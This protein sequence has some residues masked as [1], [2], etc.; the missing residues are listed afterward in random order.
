M[1]WRLGGV[2]GALVPPVQAA[3]PAGTITADMAVDAPKYEENLVAPT[4]PKYQPLLI[5]EANVLE[6]EARLRARTE[7]RISLLEELAKTMAEVEQMNGSKTQLFASS[8]P[9]SYVVIERLE[10]EFSSLKDKVDRNSSKINTLKDAVELNSTK[11]ASLSDKV[12]EDSFT[13]TSLTDK[14]NSNSN[15]IDELLI[16]TDSLRDWVSQIQDG[17]PTQDAQ[18]ASVARPPV[19]TW[20]DT[21]PALSREAKSE[22]SR[23]KDEPTSGGQCQGP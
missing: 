3:D 18:A 6:Q 4:L 14:A 7:E 19:L 15:N 23:V 20:S 13:L 16:Q 22:P 2:L 21:Y 17:Q 9:D 11:V 10:Q 1:I 8:T 5:H 12:D